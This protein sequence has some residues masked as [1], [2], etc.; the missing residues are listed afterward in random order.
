MNSRL[1]IDGKPRNVLNLPFVK[2]RKQPIIVRAVRLTRPFRVQTLEGIMEGKEG[3]MLIEGVNN[4]VYPCDYLI[5]K[6]TYEN[7]DGSPIKW[8][9][10]GGSND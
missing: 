5:F 9:I 2:V 8:V 3:D 6:Q 4:E 7:L 10:K 1:E